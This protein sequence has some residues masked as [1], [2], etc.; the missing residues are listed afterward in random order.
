MAVIHERE[1][2]CFAAEF[3]HGFGLS[4]AAAAECPPHI[5][6]QLSCSQAKGVDTL[7]AH[8]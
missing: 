2:V 8:C 3:R 4:A 6:T 7:N 5:H 1:P